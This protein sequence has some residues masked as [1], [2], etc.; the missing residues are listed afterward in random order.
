MKNLV[1]ATALAIGSLTTGTAATPI[2]F[3]VGIMEDVMA[4]DYKEV[5][6]YDI[7]TAVTDAL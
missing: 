2:I 7:P 1:F 4:Q 5:A 3:H 6:V